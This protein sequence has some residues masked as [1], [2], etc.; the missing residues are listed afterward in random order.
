MSNKMTH[1]YVC[2]CVCVRVEI[3]WQSVIAILYYITKFDMND[4]YYDVIYGQQ[5]ISAFF[6]KTIMHKNFWHMLHKYKQSCVN[7]S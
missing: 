2:E 1:M 6:L 5:A 4:T 3:D 7:L